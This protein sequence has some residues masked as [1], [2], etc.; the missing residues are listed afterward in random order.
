MGNIKLQPQRIAVIIFHICAEHN[1]HLEAQWI[2]GT[3]NE[4]AN[5]IGRLI[6]FDYWQIPQDFF[7][8]SR[9]ILG[10]AHG[11]CFA[12]F[13]TA[14]L[15]RSFSRPGMEVFV[16]ILESENCFVVPPKPLVVRALH[17]IGLTS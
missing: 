17:Y 11:E 6:K 13:Y 5:C 3:E 8:P 9:R 2:P 7:S 4:E 10:P 12:N 15:P 1:I 14:K 16:Q